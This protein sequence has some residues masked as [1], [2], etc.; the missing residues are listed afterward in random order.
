MARG[1]QNLNPLF[2]YSLAECLNKDCPVFASRTDHVTLKRLIVRTQQTRTETVQ[3]GLIHLSSSDVIGGSAS[4]PSVS[5]DNA[6]KV[7]MRFN[8][9]VRE[10]H[11][12]I[13]QK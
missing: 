7:R 3:E 5:S 11:A 4:P 9:L 1:N 6:Y 10:C 12:T 2:D 13:R 8:Y